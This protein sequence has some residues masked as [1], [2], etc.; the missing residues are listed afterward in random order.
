[1][2]EQNQA[3]IDRASLPPGGEDRSE[4]GESDAEG[5]A[6]TP[7]AKIGRPK[8]SFQTVCKRGHDTRVT[9]YTETKDGYRKCTICIR[10][11]K[12]GY[13]QAKLDI[14]HAGMD[15]VNAFRALP[16]GYPIPTKLKVKIDKLAET[17][18]MEIK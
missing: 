11:Q 14:Q 17:L 4:V 5:T 3:H 10:V 6:Q 1:M 15:V 13:Y 7:R 8:G 12:K 9:G 2:G 18:K 16:E